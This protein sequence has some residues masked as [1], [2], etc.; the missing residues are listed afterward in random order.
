MGT[1]SLHAINLAEAAYDPHVGAS[2][3]LP[4]LLRAGGASLDLRRGCLGMLGA[5]FTEHQ[6][7][8]IGQLCASDGTPDLALALMTA[9]QEIGPEVTRKHT[10]T[11][12]QSPAIE[13]LSALRESEPE[14]Y[15]VYAR[16]L[17]CKDVLSISRT[18]PGWTRRAHFDAVF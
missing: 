4:Q 14:I 13:L 3:W 15:D 9:V 1:Q 7:D 10:A 12:M 17:G 2:D 5:G 8:V 16:H 11:A 6:Q 18:R